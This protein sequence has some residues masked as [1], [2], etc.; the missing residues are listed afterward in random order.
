MCLLSVSLLGGQAFAGTY[1]AEQQDD[2]LS[3]EQREALVPEESAAAIDATL[4]SIEAS[5]QPE[6]ENQTE[7]TQVEVTAAND[8]ENQD[9]ITPITETVTAETEGSFYV[10]PPTG[11]EKSDAEL[12]LL[13]QYLAKITTDLNQTI[14]PKIDIGLTF[15]DCNMENAFYDP[16]E[17]TITFCN[18]LLSSMAKKV[19]DKN[20]DAGS[21]TGVIYFVLFHEIGHAL[22]DALD[23]P[24]TGREE[25]VADQFSIW[26][27]LTDYERGAENETAMVN[28]VVGAITFFSD[29]TL[30]TEADLAGE[31][32]LNGQRLNN[33]L[34]WAYGSN[35]PRFSMIA[36]A[37]M[38]PTGRLQRCS[39]EYARINK[40]MTA[41]LMPYLK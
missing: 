25:D 17:K 13:H 28:A 9:A 2:Q 36:E 19:V 1:E 10:I 18:E 20:E 21:F 38:L 37:E 16:A 39:G 11:Q 30:V 41:L 23:L 31:H 4:M 3:V 35:I 8:V 12:M 24:I 14:N 15:Q 5:Q 29:D 34:C 40:A 22:I 33:V 26:N 27:M 6:V 7:T 32:P